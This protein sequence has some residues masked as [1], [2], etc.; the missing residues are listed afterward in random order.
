MLAGRL[1]H[2]NALNLQLSRE[3]YEPK[4]YRYGLGY[5]TYL[6]GYELFVMDGNSYSQVVN[7]LKYCLLK[8][9]SYNLAYI[10]WSQFNPVHL[11]I[12]SNLFFDMA[13][14]KGKYY[15]SD[16]NDYVNRLL[17]TMGLGLDVV[18]YYDQVIRF[19]VSVNR[20]GQ[21]GFFIHT[22]VPF[23]RW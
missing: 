13:Y 11:S 19:E 14:V 12:Y 23:S 5:R 16:G 18:S 8:E 22:E 17:Y 1:Y 2:N 10:P 20:E 3:N 15:S 4:I 21:A 6:R 7:N 9:R